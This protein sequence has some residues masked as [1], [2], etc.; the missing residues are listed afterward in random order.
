MTNSPSA[1][2]DFV[3]EKERCTDSAKGKAFVH[4]N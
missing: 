2:G 1:E 3:P 4:F